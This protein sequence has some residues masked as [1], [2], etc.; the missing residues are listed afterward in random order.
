MY[1]K[2]VPL[3][4]QIFLA[5]LFVASSDTSCQNKRK[6]V[7]TYIFLYIYVYIFLNVSIKNLVC[8]VFVLQGEK[9]VGDVKH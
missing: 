2:M 8:E 4:S 9:V 3:C 7:Q 1:I 5:F 6:N